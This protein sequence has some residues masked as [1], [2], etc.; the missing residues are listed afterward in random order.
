[1][2]VDYQENDA[3]VVLDLDADDPENNTISWKLGGTDVDDFGINASGELTFDAS[4]DYENPTDS[5]R[6]NEYKVIVEASDGTNSDS[7]EISVNVTN[8]NEPPEV[9]GPSS[10][11][12][13]E[14]RGDV[15]A[16]YDADDPENQ[17]VTWKLG[18]TD[19][20]DFTLSDSGALRFRTKPTSKTPT[21]TTPTTN[22][23]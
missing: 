11:R 23:R 22:T 20:H 13:L 10:V 2:A 15:V 1:M 4:P 12:Y 9:T 5:N 16:D 21:M 14:N 18:G 8:Q 6:N 7:E 17:D 3:S 19:A